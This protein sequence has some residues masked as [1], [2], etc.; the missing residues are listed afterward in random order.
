M[1][2]SGAS[3]SLVGRL[4]ICSML[5]GM[6]Y[7]LLTTLVEAVQVENGRVA[8]ASALASLGCCILVLGLVATGELGLRR[9]RE[10]ARRASP[11]SMP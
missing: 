1:V 7:W 8:Q 10:R 2:R 11:D 5:C 6:Q 4:V 9:S 3:A